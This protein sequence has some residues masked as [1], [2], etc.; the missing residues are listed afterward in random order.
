MAAQTSEEE[1][2]RKRRQRLIQGL[3]MGGAAIGLPALFNALVS[4]RARRIPPARWGSNDRYPWHGVDVV[5]QSLG[6]GRPLVLLH[7]FGPG[8]AGDEWRRAAELLAENARVFV[9][10]L[11]GWGQSG[12]A[13]A[14]SGRAYDGELYIELI[15][16]FLKDVVREPAVL[17]AAGLPAAYA[18]QIAVDQPETVLGL[19]LVVPHGMEDHSDEPDIKDAVVHR[20]LRL[21]ILGTS[22]LN[23]YTSHSAMTNYLRHEVYASPALVDDALVEEHFRRAH[24]PGAQGA[25]AAYLSGYLNHG[26]RELLGRLDVPV[27]IAW[28]RRALTPSIESADL[29][30]HHLPGA[31]LEVLEQCGVLP[32]AESPEELCRKLEL[33]LGKL[34]DQNPQ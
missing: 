2:R 4:R 11:L 7:S 5:Y 25:L 15:S 17:A 18:V 12:T 10:D 24:Q 34:N 22:A 6:Q 16:Q 14:R 26:V 20:L 23:L 8:H 33:F 1:Q 19:G 21:P 29:W 3:A 30:L 32:H 13:M 27:W 28:G 9:P 31:G